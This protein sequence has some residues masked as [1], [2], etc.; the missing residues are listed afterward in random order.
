MAD[1]WIHH[2]A[3]VNG[4]RMHYVVAGSGYPLVLLHGWPQTWYEWRKIIPAIA[5]RFTVIAPDLRGLGDSECPA[6]GYDKRTLASDVYQLVKTLG[7]DSIGLTGHDWGGTVAYYLAYDHPEMVR[8]LLILESI[9]GTRGDELELRGI[10]RQ[11]HMFFHGCVPDL[12]ELLVRDHIGLY[13]DRL[14]SV[15]CYDPDLFSRDEMAEYV[16]AYSRPGSLQAGFHYYRAGLDEDVAAFRECTR[17]LEMPVRAWGGE[18]FMGDITG[19]WKRVAEEVRGGS[20]ERC[21]HFMAEE[22]P[23]FV[24]QQIEEF[25][26]PLS[27]DE[28]RSS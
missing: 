21:G 24:L 7:Y 2:T 15:A 9:P 20:V 13:L 14:C 6:T 26:A 25:F 16:R 3:K 28:T 1:S 27:A 11:W 23:D 12:A 18:R 19:A 5:Q 22:R 4:F 8:R 17:K 10:R